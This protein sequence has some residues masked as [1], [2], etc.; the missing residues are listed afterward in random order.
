[1]DRIERRAR[2]VIA[3][4]E[5]EG[6]RLDER[7]KEDVRRILRGDLCAEV[8]VARLRARVLGLEG[9]PPA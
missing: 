2:N 7:T 4:S 9:C 8:A 5:A 6:V 1:M 3:S